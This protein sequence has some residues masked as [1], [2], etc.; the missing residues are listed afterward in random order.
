MAKIGKKTKSVKKKVAASVVKKT[1]KTKAI[2]PTKKTGGTQKV[3]AAAGL[4]CA[5][6][7]KPMRVKKM[8]HGGTDGAH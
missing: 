6:C 8:P 4:K 1:A 7:E 3:S 5:I 2:K